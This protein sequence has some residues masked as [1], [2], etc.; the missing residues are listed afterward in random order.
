MKVK[1]LIY[2]I[3]LMVGLMSCVDDKYDFKNI[4]PT[5]ELSTELVGPLAYSTLN[6]V[7]ILNMDNYDCVIDTTNLT[8]DQVAEEMI[9][10][11]L[12]YKTEAK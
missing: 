6:I 8:P 7:D 2:V 4:D 12:E 5:M 1:S 9:K 3:L 11:Y 10:K